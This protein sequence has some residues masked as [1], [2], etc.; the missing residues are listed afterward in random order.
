MSFDAS[1]NNV[2]EYYSSHYLTSTFSKDVK[3]LIAKWRQQGSN[4]VPRRIQQLSQLYFRAKT[5]AL[6]EDLPENRW[7]AGDDLAA[8]HVYLL[9]NLGYTQRKPLDIPVEGAKNYVPVVAK[10]SRYNQPWLVI[11]ESVFCLPSTSLKD[12]MA[13][14]DPMEM[15]PVNGQLVDMENPLCLDNWGRLI[16]RVFTEENAPRWVM[17]LAGSLVLLLDKHTYAQG[18]YLSFDFDDAFG[19]NEKGTFEH[20]AAFLSAQTLCPDGE[21][22]ELIHD[23]LE[24]QSHRFA[25]GVTENLQLAVR[26]AIFELANE[27]VEDRRRRNLSMMERRLKGEILPDGSDEI[28]AE[29]LKHETLIFVYRLLFCFYAEARGGEL[30]ILPITDD[31]YRLGYSLESLRDLEQVPLTATTEEGIY[32][33]DHLRILFQIIHQGIN[34]RLTPRKKETRPPKQSHLFPEPKRPEQMD[35]FDRADSN[36]TGYQHK[37]FTIRPL[38]ATLF[39]PSSTPLLNNARLSNRCLQNVICRLSL[40]KDEKNKSI[41]RVNYAELGINQLGAIYEGLLSYKGMFA[42]EDLIQV[43]SPKGDF[44]DK[45]TPTWYVPYSRLDEFRNEKKKNIVKRLNDGKLL[46]YNQGTFILHLSGIDREQSASYY[47]PEP[48]TKCLVEE[49]LRELLI[50]YTPADADEI[51]NLKVCEPAMGSGAFLNEA[52][53]QLAEHY[54]NLKQK[55]IGQT[56]EPGRYLDELRRVKHYITTRNVYGVDLNPTAVEL[57]AL[58]LWLGSIHRLLVKKGENGEPDRYQSG[59]TPWFGLR[60][61]C[62]NS[63]IGARRA[64]WTSEQLLKGRHYGAKSEVPRQLKPGEARGEKEIDHFLVFDEEMA[65]SAGDQ[66]MRRFHPEACARARG[67]L[68]T[69]VKSKWDQEEIAEAKRI[70]EQIDL[71]WEKFTRQRMTSLAETACTATVWPQPSDSAAAL[72]E[73]PSLQGQEQVRAGLEASSGAFQRLK[74]LMDA[75]CALWLWPLDEANKLPDRRAFLAASGLLAGDKPPGKALRPLISANLGFEIE[76]VI[77]A[78]GETLPDADLLANLV[79]WMATSRRIASEQPFHHWELVF[80]EI[81]GPEAHHRGFDLMVGNPPWIKAS[82]QDALVLA[83]IEPLLG[84]KEAR[85]A[86]YNRQRLDLLQSEKALRVYQAAHCESEG[87]CTFLNGKRNYPELAGVQNN[88]YKNFIVRAWQLLRVSGIVGLLHPEGPYDDAAGGRLREDIYRRLKGHYQ[89]SNELKLFSDNDHHTRFSINIYGETQRI[90]SFNHM[91]NLFVP[92]TLADSLSHD[93]PTDPLP[94]IK[95]TE[96]K[97]EVRPHTHRVVKITGK[98]LELYARLFEE[99]GTP[100]LQTRLP[101]IHAQAINTVIEKLAQAPKRLMDLEGEFFATEMFHESN[102]QRDGILM[103]KDNPSHQPAFA[104]DWVLSG[105]HFFVGTPLNKTPREACTHN[106]AYDDIDLTEIPE[107]Y[108]PRTVYRPGNR[109]G[110]KTSFYSAIAEWPK[111]SLPGFWPVIGEEDEL[112]WEVLLGEPPQVYGIDPNKPGARTARRF[113]C[114]SEIKG[115]PSKILLW[116]RANQNEIDL[117]RIADAVEEFYFRQARPEEVDLS[118]LPRPITSYYRFANRQMLSISTERTMISGII[119]P[120]VTHINAVISSAFL[121]N[122]DCVAFCTS[123]TSILMDFVT[124]LSGRSNCHS[125]FLEKLP[126]I[127]QHDSLI[128]QMLSRSL[129]LNCLTTAYADLWCDVSGPWIRDEQ[130]TSNDPRL[131]HEFEHPWHL[132]NPDAW[133]WKTPL[134]TGFARRQA[135]LEIDVLVALALG[136]T[137]EE[138]LTIY[139]VQFPVMRQYE[140]VDEYDVKG[141]HIPN[142][143]RKNPGAKEFRDA[144]K[145]WDGKS[146]LTVS[147]EIDNGLKTVTKT[148]YP[149]FTGVDREADYERAYKV[150]KKRYGS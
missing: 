15:M 33:H 143:T 56:I 120:I 46:V 100:P 131:C 16:G 11:C 149:P 6:E 74:I 115:D 126:I 34:P 17:F 63:L 123:T 141:R 71:H 137:L 73:G 127:Q 47:T 12:G 138:L 53:E 91:S 36:L 40:S 102:S 28:T 132:L 124:K 72:Q 99:A 58:S 45:R 60:L 3:N 10:I 136:L 128:I 50:G 89:F 24:E 150:F 134:R 70:C 106:N 94:G 14:E 114:L 81:M 69:Q 88:L 86:D 9:E 21:S 83:E 44:K 38:T 142:T 62:G 8:W 42:K 29:H 2:G 80:P 145:I 18:R 105:P 107:I 48:L 135:L 103:R 67:W 76:G 57:G 112:A 110:D 1:I 98:E 121:S 148:F 84:V 66:L 146:P 26:E 4:A 125:S 68:S 43:K 77:K 39:D 144:R 129:R 113:I 96:G 61:R 64:V 108:L 78:A 85:S 82:W 111:P 51:L 93:R 116:M 25:H 65:P 52:S 90:V 75:W 104:E 20:F 19:R 130:W 22:D 31:V 133:D 49:A 5:Q 59:A 95:N 7:Q 92:Q 109:V 37:T 118:L 30:N 101:Q 23:K 79:P 119:P 27:W 117:S 32:F 55:Q 147:W 41:G 54:L 87:A 139:Q 13:S 97:W 140:L 122:I 35:L